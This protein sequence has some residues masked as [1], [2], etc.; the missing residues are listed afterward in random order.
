MEYHTVSRIFTQ[1]T[2]IR[3]FWDK[4]GGFG[5]QTASIC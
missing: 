2:Q 1:V 5:G 4:E 3:A